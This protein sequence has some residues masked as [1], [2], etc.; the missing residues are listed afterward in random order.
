[1]KFGKEFWLILFREYISLKLF[2]ECISQSLTLNLH[3]KKNRSKPHRILPS[4][5]S[6]IPDC[7]T[8]L[9]QNPSLLNYILLSPCIPPPYTEFLPS[10][11]H[12][13]IY[14]YIPHCIPPSHTIYLHPTLHP[15][16]HTFMPNCIPPSQIVSLYLTLHPPMS[17]CIPSTVHHHTGSLSSP[18]YHSISQCFHPPQCTY[19][20][21]SPSAA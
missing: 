16:M 3:P 1:M 19:T 9:T 15:S 2:A 17:I 6:S 5:Y 18:P 20:L 11:L 13:T 21:K 4:T 10:K 12:L 7:I 8:H 14:S